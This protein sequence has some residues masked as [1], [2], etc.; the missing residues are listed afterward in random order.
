MPSHRRSVYVLSPMP[1]NICPFRSATPNTLL[2]LLVVGM[3][4]TVVSEMIGRV[5]KIKAATQAAT[6]IDCVSMSVA[7]D[8]YHNI[9]RVRGVK[10]EVQT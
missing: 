4:A 8:L 5:L 10:G 2:T 9:S 6:A 1:E 3:S 7:I